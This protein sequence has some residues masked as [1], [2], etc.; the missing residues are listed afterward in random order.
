VTS[1]RGGRRDRNLAASGG[2]AAF[3]GALLI[4]VAV[5]VGIALLASG[6]DDNGSDVAVDGDEETTTTTNGTS[7]TT[8]TVPVGPRAPAEVKVVVLNG[9]GKTGV[10]KRS[11]DA[12]IALGYSTLPAA[13][14][15]QQVPTTL[16]YFVEGYETEA[17]A[18][19]QALSLAPAAAQPLPEPPPSPPGEAHLMVILG[20][21]TPA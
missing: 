4:A 14:A 16:V 13:N 5:I 19:A 21:D 6:L 17:L 12:L 1:P 2:S 9:S 8:A 3:R 15:P 11:T 20:Q 7:D 10:A 18:V